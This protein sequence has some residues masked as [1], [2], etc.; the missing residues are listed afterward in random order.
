MP[1]E[2]RTPVDIVLGA[3]AGE[4]EFWTST[5]EFVAN[6]QQRY[7]KAYAIARENLRVQASRRKD[8]YHRK[9]VKTKFRVGQW[10]WYFYP[11]RYKGRSPK[12]SKLYV[13]P[14]LIVDIVSTTNVK[15]QKSRNSRSQV[16]HVDKL[17]VFRETTF[18]AVNRRWGRRRSRRIRRRGR[19]RVD[20]RRWYRE[21]PAVSHER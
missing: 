14:M 19:G 5:H 15:I 18:L 13:G 1:D 4:E 9:V 6:A 17:K 2:V 11:W 20:S 16:V 10:V 12:W 7:R 8:V 3:P 21:W